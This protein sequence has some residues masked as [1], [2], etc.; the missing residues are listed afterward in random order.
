[1][2]TEAL[3]PVTL[4]QLR[5][6]ET[7]AEP[8]LV[9]VLQ[10]LVRTSSV[11]PGISRGEIGGRYERKMAELVLEWLRPT[12][13]R[14]T[15]VE[16]APGRPS[17]AAVLGGAVEGPRLVLNGHMDT[18]PI[19]DPSLWTTDPF[20]AEVRDG[21]VYGRGS[22]DMKAGLTVQ[23][24]VAHCLSK[25]ADRIKGALVLHFAAGEE[26][27][28]PGTL[29]LLEAGFGGDFG[30]TT[31][32]TELHVATAERGI[33]YY[34]I[35]I[36]GRSIHASRAH[37][38]LNPNRFLPA[39]LEAIAAYEH[40]IQTRTH[41]L[42]PG[43]SCTPT[44]IRA[45]IKENAVPDNCEITLDRRLLPG[46]TAE[47]EREALRAH[48]DVIK[49]RDPMFHFDIELL[50]YGFAPAEIDRDSAF[51]KR[52]QVAIEDVTELARPITGTPFS[53]DVRNLVNE[54]GI[55]A[56]TFGPGNVAEC[57]CA[58][59]RVSIDELRSAALATAKVAVDL[60]V[61]SY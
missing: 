11:N 23:I 5:T 31:E 36:K 52:V 56:V 19:D 27:G 12:V 48:L 59:E 8:F 1:M 58:D 13:A 39:V 28:E 7:L 2:R 38:G 54:G 60:L 25:H 40:D 14:C 9:E 42:L 15:V 51:A 29:S 3:S 17:V 57:H 61:S 35:R 53:S 21:F 49:E 45:G 32:P 50:P 22:C 43:G 46:E 6:D 10:S 44:V 20:L 26:C 33:A 4:P 18:V 41:E 16:F 37:L 24:A 30:I 47:G 34:R 55:E